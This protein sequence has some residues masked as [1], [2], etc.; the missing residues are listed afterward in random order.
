[1]KMN[2][3]FNLSGYGRFKMNPYMMKKEIFED[4]KGESPS[5]N[6]PIP[7]QLGC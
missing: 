7:K 1:M 2:V 4:L 6:N 3:N 5:T